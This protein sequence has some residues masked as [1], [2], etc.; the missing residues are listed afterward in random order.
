MNLP[1]YLAHMQHTLRANIIGI[2]GGRDTR[3]HKLCRRDFLTWK[4]GKCVQKPN[5][6]RPFPLGL[7]VPRHFSSCPFCPP[8]YFSTYEVNVI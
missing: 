5:T 1:I 2:S 8:F 6:P 4:Y 7:L 3:N